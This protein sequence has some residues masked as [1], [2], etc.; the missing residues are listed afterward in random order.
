MIT[1]TSAARTERP[2]ALTG[3]AGSR[4][5]R[6]VVSRRA[7]LG[8]A[9]LLAVAAKELAPVQ[10]R[11]PGDDLAAARQ[12]LNAYN[13]LYR[14]THTLQASWSRYTSLTNPET[15]PTGKEFRLI[16]VTVPGAATAEMAAA[17]KVLAAGP[18][19]AEADRAAK[20][21]IHF[22]REAAPLM[23]E[24]AAF[25]P[26]Y[27]P[28][29]DQGNAGQVWH[30]RMKSLMSFTVDARQD[31]FKASDA[32]RGE[33]EPKELALLEKK[34]RGALWHVQ[35]ASIEA[36]KVRDVFPVA[37]G[38]IALDLLQEKLKAFG[39]VVET[40]RAFEQANP[41][42]LTLFSP[43]PNLFQMSITRLQADIA[44]R[45]APQLATRADIVV[46]HMAYA[47]LLQFSD[48]FF[49]HAG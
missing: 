19:V 11:A 23:T 47:Q 2:A 13:D 22:Y 7:L 3:N 4:R 12:K 37:A 14:A 27:S 8:S 32:L 38:E 45:P 29:E 33:I 24:A 36:R 34:G 42:K 46:A 49:A 39:A 30:R 1:L 15:G 21:L 31:L 25:Y 16:G 6:D 48:L 26:T 28:Q 10:A 20:A 9:V 44:G 35:M 41:G 18:P 5:S 43:I 40:C 17:E